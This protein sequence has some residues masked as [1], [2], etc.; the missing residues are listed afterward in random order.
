MSMYRARRCPKC[1]Y[2]VG[3]SVAKPFH[4]TPEAAVDSFCLNCNYQL[5]VRAVLRGRNYS[6]RP[7][8]NKPAGMLQ[9]ANDFHGTERLNAPSATRDSEAFAQ[10]ANYPR[11]LRA[12]GQELEKR[13]FTTFNLT[14]SG[15]AYFVWS[16]EIIA[17]PRLNDLASTEG[18]SGAQFRNGNTDDP[19]MKLLLDRLVG[20][21][22]NADEVE[23]LERQG[24]QNRR[25]ESGVSNGSHLSHLLRTVGEQVHRRNQRLLAIAWQARRIGVVAETVGGRCEMKILRSDNLYDLWVR[26]YLQRSH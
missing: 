19:A 1:Q 14:C 7:R 2:Y 4:G 10:P 11:D 18:E 5:P 23:R 15:D 6:A 25:Q 3:Y 12:I 24:V 16:T 8:T 17:S 21:Q 22:F 20:F 13:R 9:R 26:M